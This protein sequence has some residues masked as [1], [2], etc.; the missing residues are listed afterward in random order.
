MGCLRCL[1]EGAGAFA[2][3]AVSLRLFEPE[4]FRRWLLE[5]P[6]KRCEFDDDRRRLSDGAKLRL[7]DDPPKRWLP[8]DD[9]RLLFDEPPKRCE[10]D[11]ARRRLLE[12]ATRW[13]FDE[14]RR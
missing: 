7:P 3:E 10:P 9:R 13:L 5:E 12:A 11:E 6:P 14:G 2:S 1:A 8:D 4:R